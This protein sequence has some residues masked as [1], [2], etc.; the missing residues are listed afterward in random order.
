M[1]EQVAIYRG[2]STVV[3]VQLKELVDHGDPL[4]NMRLKRNDIVFVPSAK[5]VYIS[6]LGEVLHPG[7]Y[8][9]ES[10]FHAAKACLRSRRYPSTPQG[11]IP[12]SRSFP[13]PPEPPAS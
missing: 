1:P 4:A 2:N 10:S 7:T 5:D 11:A 9:L 3:W 13:D 6:V 12:R 8:Q